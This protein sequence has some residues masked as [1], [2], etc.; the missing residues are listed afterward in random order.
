MN[1][2]KL[3]ELKAVGVIRDLFN[4]ARRRSVYRT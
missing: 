4:C 2:Q 3:D 1:I